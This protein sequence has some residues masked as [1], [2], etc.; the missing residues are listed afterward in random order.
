MAGWR[1]RA[2]V[3][4]LGGAVAL[5]TVILCGIENNPENEN[6]ASRASISENVSVAIMSISALKA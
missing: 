4:W 6:M 5:S 3:A 2:M 1:H